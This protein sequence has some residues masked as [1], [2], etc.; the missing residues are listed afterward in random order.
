MNPNESLIRLAI[1]KLQPI[2][3]VYDDKPRILC[4]HVIGQKGEKINVLSYQI[5]G[6]SSRPLGPP[7][8]PDNWRCM[9]LEK[10]EDIRFRTDLAWQTC[11]THTQPQTCVD[12]IYA[13]VDY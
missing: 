13:E 12:R 3:T 2:E 8:S 5:G 4:P 10:L 11:D 7:E 1:R 6:E 9:H